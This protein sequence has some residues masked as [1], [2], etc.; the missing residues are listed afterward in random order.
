[1]KDRKIY[2]LLTDTGT[3]LT[4][5]IR[6]YTKK[7]Y[8]HASLSLDPNLT[9]VYSF[10]RKRPN[11]PFIGGFVKENIT[12]GPLREADCV[13]YSCTVSE[14]QYQQIQTF[15]KEIEIQEHLYRYNFIGLFAFMLKKELHR[16]N[17]Y[18]CSEFVATALSNSGIV[19]LRKPPSFVAPHDFEDIRDF[20]LEFRGKLA[21]FYRKKQYYDHLSLSS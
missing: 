9:E 5:V 2:I 7:T 17:A 3:V 1:M 14:R 6:L 16:K 19:Q 18:F 10:G 21:S 13:I 11:N 15:L 4:R 20:Q 8:N 12:T